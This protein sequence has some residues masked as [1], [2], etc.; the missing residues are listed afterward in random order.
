[1][2]TGVRVMLNM[3]RSMELEYEGVIKIIK[4]IIISAK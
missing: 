1:M 4:L 3:G 2:G